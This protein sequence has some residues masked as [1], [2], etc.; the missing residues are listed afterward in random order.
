MDRDYGMFGKYDVVLGARVY[1][2][3][4]A[5]VFVS[6]GEYETTYRLDEPEY[7]DGDSTTD[8]EELS[9]IE[10]D[11][12]SW[13]IDMA[14]DFGYNGRGEQALYVDLVASPFFYDDDVL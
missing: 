10:L 9:Y 5:G 12:K 1:A 7:T 14:E 4:A 8:P 13:A 2:D 11:A 3:P 6:L